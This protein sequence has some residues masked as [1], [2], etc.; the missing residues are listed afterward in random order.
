MKVSSSLAVFSIKIM[1]KTVSFHVMKIKK[2]FNLQKLL[3]FL[4]AIIVVS[5]FCLKYDV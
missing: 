5:N 1:K 3:T 4:E 2:I